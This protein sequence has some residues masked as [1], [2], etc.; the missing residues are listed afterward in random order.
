[1]SSRSREASDGAGLVDGV[2]ST[3]SRQGG[4]PPPSAREG[5]LRKHVVTVSG[6]VIEL[7]RGLAGASS[8]K[9]NDNPEPRWCLVEKSTSEASEISTM[10]DAR[11]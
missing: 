1:M 2:G 6:A 7:G 11:S 3:S 4:S 8:E 5:L 10:D 9:A